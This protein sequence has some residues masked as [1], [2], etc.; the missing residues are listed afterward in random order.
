M[1]ALLSWWMKVT[2]SQGVCVP[3]NESGFHRLKLILCSAKRNRGQLL[4][5]VVKKDMGED[6]TENDPVPDE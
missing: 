1:P 5:A 4:G 3:R 2:K 6:K